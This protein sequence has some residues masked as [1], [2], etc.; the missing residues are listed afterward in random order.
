MPVEL[1]ERQ[2]EPCLPG[3]QDEPS[4]RAAA[5]VAQQAAKVVDG[6]HDAAKTGDAQEIGDRTRK[7]RYHPVGEQP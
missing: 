6:D 7:R 2:T 5:F 3:R 1:I 4:R